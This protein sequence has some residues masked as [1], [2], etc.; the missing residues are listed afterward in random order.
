MKSPTPELLVEPF[1]AAFDAPPRTRPVVFKRVGTAAWDL[2][3]ARVA[4]GSIGGAN[5]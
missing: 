5:A 1:A 4:L 2:A 3:A